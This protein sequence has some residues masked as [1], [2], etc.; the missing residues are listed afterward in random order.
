M[1][2]RQAP[3]PFGGC[4][5]C[6]GTDVL[7]GP[8]ASLAVSHETVERELPLPA[9]ARL[10]F[11]MGASNTSVPRLAAHCVEPLR[12]LQHELLKR[13]LDLCVQTVRVRVPAQP[14]VSSRPRTPQPPVSTRRMDEM[15][16]LSGSLRDPFA[17]VLGVAELCL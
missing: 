14:R 7:A 2:R 3:R 5:C 17:A 12:N 10:A 1:G 6:V 11:L 9:A 13:I 4:V 8:A 16:L 15:S